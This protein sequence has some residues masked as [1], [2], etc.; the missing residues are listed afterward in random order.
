MQ[1]AIKRNSKVSYRIAQ[2][3]EHDAIQEVAK[4]SKFLHDFHYRV[5]WS[6]PQAYARGWIRVAE[7]NSKIV[8]FISYTIKRNRTLFINHMGV[9]PQY[10]RQG[11]GRDLIEMIDA[12]V[13]VAGFFP[14]P[15]MLN[16][17]LRNEEAM[18][19]YRQMG[20]KVVKPALK[21]KGVLF[22][23]ERIKRSKVDAR[24]SGLI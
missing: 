5:I 3:H 19:F 2:E 21:G 14:R 23:R 4:T 11:I 16:C 15:M 9:D 13:P 10:R 8:G 12:A 18:T 1:K 7:Y 22:Q 24:K 20:F 17:A 6:P